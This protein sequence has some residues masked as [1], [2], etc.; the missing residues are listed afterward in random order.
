MKKIIFLFT[1]LFF[2]FMSGL[3]VHAASSPISRDGYFRDIRLAGRVRIVT[4]FPD[5]KVQ[6]V[7]SFPDFKVKAVSAF[8]DHIGE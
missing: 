8:P 2:L 7:S 3:P 4:S 6:V 1:A 5:I